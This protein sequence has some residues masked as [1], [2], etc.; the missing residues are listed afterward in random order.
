VDILPVIVHFVTREERSAKWVV[1][2]K[3]CAAKQTA[4]AGEQGGRPEELSED[5]KRVHASSAKGSAG[6]HVNATLGSL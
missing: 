2:E 1:A 5:I 6:S 3:A 4:T